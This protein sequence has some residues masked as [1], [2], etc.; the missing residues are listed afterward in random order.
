MQ[1]CK[2]APFVINHVVALRF[3][4]AQIYL[5]SAAN[6]AMLQTTGDHKRK[7]TLTKLSGFHREARHGSQI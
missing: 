7:H 6:C 5:E 2:A 4:G 1:E 3:R